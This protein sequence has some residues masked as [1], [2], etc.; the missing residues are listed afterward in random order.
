MRVRCTWWVSS[1]TFGAPVIANRF[2]TPSGKDT[3]PSPYGVQPLILHTIWTSLRNSSHDTA[4]GLSRYSK[5][6]AVPNVVVDKV[7]RIFC[8]VSPTSCVP[9]NTRPHKTRNPRRPSRVRSS[10]VSAWII[11]STIF[12][13]G[14]RCHREPLGGCRGV[15]VTHNYTRRLRVDQPPGGSHSPPTM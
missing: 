6:N 8:V 5:I 7:R 12:G 11:C 1:R 13:R 3:Q 9:K 15:Y 2:S 14:G 10:N 4:C